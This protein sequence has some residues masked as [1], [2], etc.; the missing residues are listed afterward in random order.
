V[1]GRSAVQA[2]GSVDGSGPTCSFVASILHDTV[3]V[4]LSELIVALM[5]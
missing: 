5:V 2:A 1:A 3:A 4:Q